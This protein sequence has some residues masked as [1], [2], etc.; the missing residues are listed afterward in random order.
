ML[1][2]PRSPTAP[3]AERFSYSRWD[4]TQQVVD[5]DAIGI[6]DQMGEDLMYHGD[7]ASALRRLM[8]EGF[9][10]SGPEGVRERVRGLREL[11]ERIR[12]RRAELSEM[13]GDAGETFREIARALEEVVSIERDGIANYRAAAE[14][15]GDERR[16]RTALATAAEREMALELL[17]DDLA[18]KF[19]SL[20]SYEFIS[21]EAQRRFDDLKQELRDQVAGMYFSQLSEALSSV[22]PEDLA[23][24][25]EAIGALNRM[26]EQRRSG[27]EL[28]PSFE[29]FM[30]QYGDLFPGSPASLDDL[31]KDLAERM[32]AVSAMLG[33]MT[34][35]QR[36]QLSSL[37]DQLLSDMDLAW[38]VER[39]SG[40][41]R[42]LFPDAGWNRT[43]SVS[44]S[45]PVPLDSLAS[46]FQEAG[47]LDDLE[48]LL[49]S[50]LGPGWLAEADMDRV[51]ELLGEDEARSL[52]RLSQV[53]RA[54]TEAGLIEQREG[55]LQLTARG[56]R[57]IG[58]DA[59]SELFSRISADR[60][61]SHQRRHF[62]SGHDAEEG[63]KPYEF[64]DPFRLNI[65]ASIRNAVAR[66][67]PGVPVRLA[68]EDLE[69]DRTE[70]V[71]RSATVLAL[72]L[73]LSMPMR[74]NFL[75]AKKV[76]LALHT[77][78]SSRYPHDYLG[79]V[80]FS[81]VAR[82][83]SPKDLPS[84]SWDFVYGTNL[85]HALC[86]ARRML[87]GQSG[88]K[89]VIVVT[90]GEPTAHLDAR[91]EVF[92]HYPPVA[93]TIERSLAEVVR[94]TKENITINTFAL[95]A[96]GYLRAFVEKMTR[97]NRGRAFFTDS[98]SLGRYVLV[99]FMD[100]RRT[101]RSSRI[102]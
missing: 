33:S 56:A 34:P 41:L 60:L 18:G 74:D 77:L 66:S 84:V 14:A 23:L 7:V 70:N 27:Q 5:L 45:G 42:G 81:E 32:A 44:G 19:R 94:C 97:I 101:A 95:D 91:G 25:R 17:P 52:E 82:E 15:S 92:F 6:F 3:V 49:S 68:P 35:E 29:Q 61:G 67:N 88:T 43:V 96:E 12:K 37:V 72:D 73:S 36:A 100:S 26:I 78:I 75:P 46:I 9:D 31:L 79:V 64:G 76:A 57:R 98:Q 30:E 63:T 83:V 51:R 24:M 87:A 53:A 28:D 65:P 69:V 99:D 10:L 55:R 13:G 62:G 20:D 4:G 11:I 40:N 16:R 58:E 102:A 59:L 86:L 54:L 90:D 21:P 1:R 71:V 50:G 2:P 80:T 8:S 93:E 39:L 22:S 38:Q 47:E 89:Q 48:R 85:A